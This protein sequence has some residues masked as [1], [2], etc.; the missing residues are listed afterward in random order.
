[1]PYV[2]GL[3]SQNR[4]P[5]NE[6]DFSDPAITHFYLPLI[7]EN[8]G[9]SEVWNKE[10]QPNQSI[11]ILTDLRVTKNTYLEDPISDAS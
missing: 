6:S 1:M 9:R 3:I 2:L 10:L 7:A 4:S 5:Q 8:V 11:S